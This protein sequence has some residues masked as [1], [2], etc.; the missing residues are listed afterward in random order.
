MIRALAIATGTLLALALLA[1]SGWIALNRADAPSPD[2]RDLRLV[3]LPATRSENGFDRLRAA[4]A[5]ARLPKGESNWDRFHAFRA[6]RIWEP[7]WISELVA[8]NAAAT[9]LLRDA[10]A[11][12]GFAFPPPE[13]AGSYADRLATLVRVQ[14]LIA[15]AGAQARILLRDGSS[16]AAIE[17]ASLGLRVGKRI[18]AA[19]N[20]DLLGIDMAIAFQTLSLLDLEHV[21]RTAYLAPD[22]AHALG[23]QLGST[24]W[25]AEDWQRIWALEYERVLAEVDAASERASDGSGLAWPMSVLPNAYRWH[26]NRTAAALAGVYRDQLRK[27]AL[28]CADAG[29]VAVSRQRPHGFADLVAPNAMGRFVIDAIRAQSFDSVQLQRCQLETHVS[30]VAALVAA[31]AWSDAEGALPERLED[32][33]PRYLDALP[34]DRYDGAP[35]RYARA[36]RAV[37]SIGEDF[38]DAGPAAAPNV[39]D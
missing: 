6:G 38:T 18:S 30:L 13:R 23:R 28:F 11:S 9:A 25:H 12:P 20:V 39:H 21:V 29:L 2:D 34:L 33:V 27:S 4:A 8:Q 7:Q 37:Y 5:A 16:G 32:L 24:R 22:A 26:P 14:Q 19:E 3:R 1:L 31:K 36:A 35:L 10:L 17:L 15:L